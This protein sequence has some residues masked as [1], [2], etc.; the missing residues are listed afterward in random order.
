MAKKLI[1]RLK[2]LLWREDSPTMVEYG[3]MLAMIAVLVAG[4][5]GF[6]GKKVRN[7]LKPRFPRWMF[8]T[9]PD[10]L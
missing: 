7:T 6:L 4:A 5:A 10:V 1:S 9:A 3:I 2:K 8:S